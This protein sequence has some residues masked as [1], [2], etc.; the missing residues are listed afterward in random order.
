MRLAR[1]LCLAIAAS[2]LAPAAAAAEP[3]FEVSASPA[4]LR[5][6]R[7]PVQYRPTITA[8]ATAEHFDLQVPGTLERG[9]GLTQV[10]AGL[11]SGIV[12]VGTRRHTARDG[13]G[14]SYE[15]FR[16]DL[17][18]GQSTYVVTGT[19][20][21]GPP[22]PDDDVGFWAR[23]YAAEGAEAPQTTRISHPGP[24]LE[25]PRG[26]PIELAAAPGPA[27]WIKVTGVATG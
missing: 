4:V 17:E 15:I 25:M 26:V 5:D 21:P 3:T 22:R 13:S 1:R 27:G 18:P 2:L 16:V 14:G 20:L 24:R 23:V 9:P 19:R 7:T 11:A 6:W 8:G 12:C 10:G